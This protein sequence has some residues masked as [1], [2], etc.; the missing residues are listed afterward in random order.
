MRAQNASPSF[1]LELKLSI[2]TFYTTNQSV[3]IGK[4]H[5]IKINENKQTKGVGGRESKGIQEFSIVNPQMD[6]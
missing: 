4:S 6:K 5:E 2:C 3:L 1:Q